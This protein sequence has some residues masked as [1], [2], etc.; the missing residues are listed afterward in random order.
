MKRQFVDWSYE[1]SDESPSS[2]TVA[3]AL[4]LLT[5]LRVR[6]QILSDLFT[7]AFPDF[8]AFLKNSF[9]EIMPAL[10]PDLTHHQLFAAFRRIPESDLRNATK[11]WSALV[12]ADNAKQVRD[13]LS[14]WATDS[15]LYD[16]WFLDHAV[17]CLRLAAT[18]ERTPLMYEVP[19][20]R[21]YF[22]DGTAHA[23]RRAV[24]YRLSSDVVWSR[25]IL[26]SAV[27]S[28]PNLAKLQTIGAFRF[29]WPEKARKPDIEIQ[30]TGWDFLEMGKDDW[31]E[32]VQKEFN[33]LAGKQWS[34]GRASWGARRKFEKALDDYL[35]NAKTAIEQLVVQHKLTK[36]PTIYDK[37]HSLENRIEWLVRY[38]IPP[39]E[40]CADIK[41]SPIH[42]NDK[43]GPLDITVAALHKQIEKIAEFIGLTLRNPR[44]HAGR[45]KGSKTS[46]VGTAGRATR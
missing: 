12:K 38:Q 39:M 18:D 6:P 45:P 16:D 15:N 25:A 21:N 17:R 27:Y 2:K 13:S 3:R 42:D 33:K 28:D 43:V 26:E 30:D 34:K 19:M 40:K 10:S 35:K 22:T 31:R 44:T 37:E 20:P 46:D 9:S 41:S 8:L 23:W 14:S 4:F 24:R 36:T 5:I 29:S 32:L 1:K 7:E 11:D